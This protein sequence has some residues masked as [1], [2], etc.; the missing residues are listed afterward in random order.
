MSIFGSFSGSEGVPN[1]LLR[2]FPVVLSRP[3]FPRAPLW[4]HHSQPLA[5]SAAAQCCTEA[6]SVYGWKVH[7]WHPCLK[8]RE[9]KGSARRQ[10]NLMQHRSMGGGSQADSEAD[11]DRNK[12]TWLRSQSK[13]QEEDMQE[14]NRRKKQKAQEDLDMIASIELTSPFCTGGSL[15]VEPLSLESRVKWAV[16]WTEHH[17]LSKLP[18]EFEHID[19]RKEILA[20]LQSSK[21]NSELCAYFGLV[22]SYFYK[23]LTQYRNTLQSKQRVARISERVR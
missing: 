21:K 12:R 3:P 23:Y 20:F 18:K 4:W 10:R 1:S 19:K 15:S 8:F 9:H 6:N 5:R 17:T 7:G 16:E 13:Q 14:R 2:P 22:P 11:A